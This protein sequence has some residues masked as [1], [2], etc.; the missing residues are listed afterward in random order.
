MLNNVLS[1]LVLLVMMVAAVLLFVAP[2]LPQASEGTLPVSVVP[3]GALNP[4]EVGTDGQWEVVYVAQDTTYGLLWFF[5]KHQD[6][7]ATIR[8][9]LALVDPAL[10]IPVL[11][12]WLDELGVLRFLKYDIDAGVYV[13]DKVEDRMYNVVVGHYNQYFGIDVQVAATV[14]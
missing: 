3:D 9:C 14:L 1:R 6:P 2:A 13:W 5:L 7:N 12:N 10:G 11:F 8:Y 4:M